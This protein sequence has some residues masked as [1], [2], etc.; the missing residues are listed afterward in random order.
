MISQEG[1]EGIINNLRRSSELRGSVNTNRGME[2][3]AVPENSCFGDDENFRSSVATAEKESLFMKQAMGNR[4]LKSTI[5]ES[6]R[7][8]DH[9]IVTD[10]QPSI[11]K[12]AKADNSLCSIKATFA[13]ENVVEVPGDEE[14]DIACG[15]KTQAQLTVSRTSIPDWTDEQLDELFAFDD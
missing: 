3:H 6:T 15:N 5:I 4:I 7:C 2:T 13:T 12:P 8:N 14:P 11:C 9:I 1:T 10:E